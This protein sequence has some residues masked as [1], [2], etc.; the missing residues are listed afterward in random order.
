[1]NV[2]KRIIMLIALLCCLTGVIFTGFSGDID[3]YSIAG[4]MERSKETANLQNHGQVN[5]FPT[6]RTFDKR[7][8]DAAGRGDA[9]IVKELIR[10]GVDVNQRDDKGLTPVHVA[11]RN[12]R[13]ETQTVL[14]LL[15]AGADIVALDDTGT[16]PL[17]NA[18]G[19][20]GTADDVRILLEH[21]AN[22]DRANLTGK[23]PLIAAA[24]WIMPAVVEML[25]RKGADPNMVD[26]K[27]NSP[28]MMA[29]V[30]G[31]DRVQIVRLL[32]EKANVHLK[33][34]DG[35][36]AL[37]IAEEKLKEYEKNQS[38]TKSL[39]EIIEELRKAGAETSCLA[40]RGFRS[41]HEL[42]FLAGLLCEVDTMSWLGSD[43]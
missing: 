41:S 6:P 38:M 7:I 11:V 23:T 19:P 3:Y 10:G 2:M 4:E 1:M 34:L 21:G 35:K 9:E 16:T 12:G 8:F 22:P 37:M 5:R 36:S 17:L 13:E 30:G 27:G 26:N 31:S 28:L 25:L 43:C 33:N 32:C 14:V 15:K 18:I 20:G 39:L 42:A 29:A 40:G 24:D